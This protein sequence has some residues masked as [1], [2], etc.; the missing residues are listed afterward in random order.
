[1]IGYTSEDEVHKILGRDMQGYNDASMELSKEEMIVENDDHWYM[2]M[3]EG[4][5]CLQQICHFNKFQEHNLF[6]KSYRLS[7]QLKDM[8]YCFHKFLFS[9][10]CSQEFEDKQ[11]NRDKEMETTIPIFYGNLW[12]TN[13]SSYG[14]S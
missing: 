7:M 12:Q 5:N 13:C 3:K 6:E 2:N 9:E 1:L 8:Q 10:K 11:E 14:R 4:I